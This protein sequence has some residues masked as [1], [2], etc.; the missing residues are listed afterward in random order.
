M[1]S[2]SSR[3]ILTTKNDFVDEINDMLITQL[4]DD[5]RTYVA[6]DETTETN[7]QSQYEDFLYS[8]HPAGL[9]PY[10]LTLKKKL[11]CYVI[12][13]FKSVRRLM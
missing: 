9:P 4:L 6:F 3:V 12:A 5:S 13:K 10:K 2:T 7:D 11:S 1:S 8:L